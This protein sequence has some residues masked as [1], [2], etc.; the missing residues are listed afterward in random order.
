MVYS[1]S[2]KA[3]SVFVAVLVLMAIALPPVMGGSLRAR[4]SDAKS[5]SSE[6]TQSSSHALARRSDDCP[7]TIRDVPNK[8]LDGPGDPFV[9]KIIVSVCNDLKKT[10]KYDNWS[11]EN[12]LISEWHKVEKCRADK[13]YS[14]ED[15][16]QCHYVPAFS[17]VDKTMGGLTQAFKDCDVPKGGSY[18]NCFNDLLKTVE[19]LYCLSAPSVSC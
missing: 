19:S 17:Y 16:S 14:I 15:C 10:V 12:I 2:S 1:N 7:A 8:T 4:A 3:F 6:L 13:F 11:C 9:K 18:T 5:K